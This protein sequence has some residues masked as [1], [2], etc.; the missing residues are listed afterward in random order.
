MFSSKYSHHFYDIITNKKQKQTDI[1][2][3]QSVNS[4]YSINIHL[5]LLLALRDEMTMLGISM[6]FEI[7]KQNRRKLYKQ[8]ANMEMDWE[9]IQER[10]LAEKHEHKVKENENNEMKW[11]K[12]LEKCNKSWR[13]YTQFKG[14]S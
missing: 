7:V 14:E 1:K 10:L 13:P 12:L 4:I 9:K 8:L 3:L 11:H 2:N 6:F 5:I